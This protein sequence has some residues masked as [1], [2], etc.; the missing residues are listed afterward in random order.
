MKII[1]FPVIFGKRLHGESKGGGTIA[2]KLKLI[3]RT[4]D[5]MIKLRKRVK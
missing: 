3:N 4:L 1:E 5:Y 2:G